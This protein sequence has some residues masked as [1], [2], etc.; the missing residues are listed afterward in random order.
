MKIPSLHFRRT[1]PAWIALALL[2]LAI[3]GARLPA[4]LTAVGARPNIIFILADDMGYGDLGCMGATDIK[5]PHID[6]L[7]TEGVKFTDFYANAPSARRPAA[8]SSRDDGSNG[9]GSSLPS[10]I[11]S[12]NSGG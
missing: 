1:R 8:V 3:G 9:W 11:W 7:A 10:V 6:R 5:T 4:Q 2:G 12:S